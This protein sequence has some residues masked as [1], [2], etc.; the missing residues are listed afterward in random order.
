MVAL[1]SPSAA[2]GN[3]TPIIV[4]Q[5]S[6]IDPDVKEN[7]TITFNKPSLRAL[8]PATHAFTMVSDTG[9][10]VYVRPTLPLISSIVDRSL[11]VCFCLGTSLQCQ[12]CRFESTEWTGES[13]LPSECHS[14]YHRRR[15]SFNVT[16]ILHSLCFESHQHFLHCGTRTSNGKIDRNRRVTARSRC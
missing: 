11:D 2:K 4:G 1:I 9:S 16:R 3:S 8:T 10:T 12:H 6:I 5:I 14:K 15:R 13:R 7:F